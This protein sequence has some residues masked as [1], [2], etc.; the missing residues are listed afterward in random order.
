MFAIYPET[1][2]LDYLNDE[3][4]SLSGLANDDIRRWAA[5]RHIVEDAI[6]SLRAARTEDDTEPAIGGLLLWTA[7]ARDYESRAIY[8]MRRYGDS[9]GVLVGGVGWVSVKRIGGFDTR[10]LVVEPPEKA[11]SGS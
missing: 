4:L 3:S 10:M 7:R 1:V 2:E 11:V 9:D 6:A 5:A 8:T